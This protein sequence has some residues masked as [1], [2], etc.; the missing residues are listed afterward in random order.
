VG[1]RPD[2]L[3][4]A[5]AAELDHP[6][7][8]PFEA[9]V[10]AVATPGQGRWLMQQLGRVLGTSQDRTDGVAARI[11]L[12]TPR[13]LFAELERDVL[14]ITRDDDP[15]ATDRLA[16]TMLRA[17]E[18][19]EQEPWFRDVA[20]HLSGADRPGRRYGVA[21]R[22]CEL[23]A[24]YARWRPDLLTMPGTGSHAW[25][26]HLWGL[27]VDLVGGPTPWART[28]D[29][30]ARLRGEP[31]LSGLPGHVSLWAPQRLAPSERT[32]LEALG[33]GRDVTLWWPTASVP[34]DHLLVRR[35]GVAGSA[36]LG[37]VTQR[38]G[39]E[40]MPSSPT[41]AT[42]LLG[43][44]Q[45]QIRTGTTGPGAPIDDP[46]V[47]V[48]LSHGLDRQVEVLRDVLCDLFDTYPDLEPR[49]VVVC[50]PQLQDVAPLVRALC[51]L[52]AE[53]LG[54][55]AHPVSTLRVRVTDPSPARTNPVLDLLWRLLDLATSRAELGDLLALCSSPPVARKF[56]LD[57]ERLETLGELL[58]R[59]GVRWGI[60]PAS[61][62]A[63]G[64]DGINQ[65]TWLA[66]LNR[67]VLGVAV[68]ERD[69][70]YV[71]SV[72]PLDMV[73]SGDLDLVGAI[74]EIYSVVRQAVT[75]FGE[76]AT[77][78]DWVV[79]FRDLLTRLVDVS[80]D[81]AWQLGHAQVLLSELATASGPDAPVIG[82][83]D[84]RHLVADWLGAHPP[85][86]TL[87]T[88]NLTVTTL[89]AL[90]HV[91][92]RVVC[93]VGV[94][95]A[96]FPRASHRSGDDLLE[97]AANPEDPHS[98]LDDRQLFLDALMAAQDAFVIV[99]AARDQRTNEPLPL[100]AP[101]IDL[102][103]AVRGLGVD[104]ES[105]VVEHALQPYEVGAEPTYDACAVEA[106]R[107]LL[108]LPRP[109]ARDRFETGGIGPADRPRVVTLAELTAFLRHP[110][111]EFLKH[112]V[113]SWYGITRSEIDTDA[114][115][116]RRAAPTEI[117][118]QLDSLD[119]WDLENRLLQLAVAGHSPDTIVEAE[120]RRGQ[121]P[122]NARGT[123]VLDR[124]T[125]RVGEVLDNLRPYL[126]T[127]LQHLDLA[128]D[129]PS[130][131][132]VTGRVPVRGDTVVE[133]T[134]SKPADKRLVEPWLRLLLLSA[135]TDG[136]W[137]SVV[138]STRR[139]ASLSAMTHDA[140]A[141][142]LDRLVAL[143]FDGWD[144]PLPLPPRV[145]FELA[146][147]RGL[148][149]DE[150]L[151]KVWGYDADASWLLFFAD[152]AAVEDAAASHGGLRRLAQDTYGPL[153]EALR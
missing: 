15:W 41:A 96:S 118:V 86:S 32:L 13:N 63:F 91:P 1:D 108:T 35:L 61:R 53:G 117:P 71:S 89:E 138:C 125:S 33:T 102:L 27:V 29:A 43:R 81:D 38:I 148:V 64:L 68:S 137:R 92:H 120:R 100:S 139:V 113:G 94:D 54:S 128:V 87:L 65:N 151:R 123:E 55:N 40:A 150:R 7:H 70:A 58:E 111:R 18:I 130:G 133:A 115:D 52:D 121:L 90:R 127:P 101:I 75:T 129:L 142:Q 57:D 20:I 30:A 126:S 146:D 21:R 22:L 78:V 88:G 2:A 124:A 107:A 59:A 122:P 136:D 103:D 76:P 84:M 82:L 152:L 14:C 31:G 42:T 25:Q 4:A 28:D 97:L 77:P 66:G 116:G 95:E 98:S 39:S 5:L 144:Q 46:S 104:R 62:A 23:F 73:D 8:D 110:A 106:R 93:M 26:H 67:L 24:H 132:R 80:T 6:R 10:I 37:A 149:D 69:L 135:S 51:M 9:D 45:Q 85:R 3:V 60:D 36:A 72:L 50:T 34:G 99:G 131:I 140:A 83:G 44:L 109:V 16:W 141:A 49:D 143:M 119:A 47:R 105:V 17:F 114:E 147:P 112:R 12:P 48:H 153:L 56:R 134:T 19:A 79:R 145:G 74:A 11:E